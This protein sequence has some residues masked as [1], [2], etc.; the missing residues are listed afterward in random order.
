MLMSFFVFIATIK[1]YE[2]IFYMIHIIWIIIFPNSGNRPKLQIFRIRK[3]VAVWVDRCS[4]GRCV[5][6]WVD[7]RNSDQQNWAWY[8]NFLVFDKT[9]NINL[10]QIEI[11]KRK[12]M[13]FH[14]GMLHVSETTIIDFFCFYHV[15]MA[16]KESIGD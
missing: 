7:F 3:S 15:W 11:K 8:N 4:L 5:A 13:K 1:K 12:T 9:W 16:I 6:V 2:V 10:I 14:I